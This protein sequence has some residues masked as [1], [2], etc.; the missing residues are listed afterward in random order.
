MRFLN[1]SFDWQVEKFL[2]FNFC[3]QIETE[4]KFD[5][6]GKVLDEKEAGRLSI[7]DYLY[8]YIV[9]MIAGDFINWTT[10]TTWT[11]GVYEMTFC[12]GRNN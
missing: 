5:N 6:V 8:E 9:L 3:L 12:F 1:K 2:H 7:T 11:P 10:Y 4:V